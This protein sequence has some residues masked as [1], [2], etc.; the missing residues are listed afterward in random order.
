MHFFFALPEDKM[1]SPILPKVFT[2]YFA[3]FKIF[4]IILHVVD[5]PFV[6][7]IEII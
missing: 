1:G 2:L 7:V 5:F 6:P 4:S 3:V